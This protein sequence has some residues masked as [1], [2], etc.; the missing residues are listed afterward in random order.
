MKVFVLFFRNCPRM[1]GRSKKEQKKVDESK[2]K[3]TDEKDS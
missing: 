1:N 2:R 3:D